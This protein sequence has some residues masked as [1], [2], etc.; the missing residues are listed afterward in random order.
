MNAVQ[1]ACV[2]EHAAKQMRMSALL[3]F[4]RI[5][6]TE[7]DRGFFGENESEKQKLICSES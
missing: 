1:A 7:R 6:G 5:G 3:D 4:D 2:H